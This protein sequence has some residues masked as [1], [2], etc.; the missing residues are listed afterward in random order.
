MYT[1]VSHIYEVC[2]YNIYVHMVVCECQCNCICMYVCMYI[3]MHACMSVS[4]SIITRMHVLVDFVTNV[5]VSALPYISNTS[6]IQEVCASLLALATRTFP[7]LDVV[8][9]P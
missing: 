4:M 8:P 5:Y 1:L 3:C 2:M 7:R 6:C 9:Q